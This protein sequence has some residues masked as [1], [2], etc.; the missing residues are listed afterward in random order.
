MWQQW[1]CEF[2]FGFL[3]IWIIWGKYTEKPTAVMFLLLLRHR[4]VPAGSLHQPYTEWSLC[5]LA[6][7]ILKI[8]DI[9]QWVKQN[10]TSGTASALG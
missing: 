5:Y 7:K 6:N 3:I 10:L 1:L 9:Y 2:V 4:G 8:K